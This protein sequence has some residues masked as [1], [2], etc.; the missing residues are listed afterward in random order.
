LDVPLIAKYRKYNYANELD[1]QDVWLVFNLD[2][3][4]GKFKHQLSQT[5][6]FL[7]KIAQIEPRFQGYLHDISKVKKLS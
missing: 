6:D 2:I 7:R 5:K 1:E 3:D 4:Y